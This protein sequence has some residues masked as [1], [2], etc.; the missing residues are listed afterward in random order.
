MCISSISEAGRL[1]KAGTAQPRSF[2]EP[3]RDASEQAVLLRLQ[4][5]LRGGTAMARTSICW[6]LHRTGTE[7][8]GHAHRSPGA[9]ML[10]LC[11]CELQAPQNGLSMDS[12]RPPSALPL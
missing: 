7:A 5:G 10:M 11:G 9:A 1:G 6:V 12:S 4:T 2:T 8:A 3:A